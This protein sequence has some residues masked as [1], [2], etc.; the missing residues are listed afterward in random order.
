MSYVDMIQKTAL[1]QGLSTP[2]ISALTNLMVYVE[3]H[4]WQGACHSTSSALY[5]ALCELGLSPKLCVGEC[6][7]GAN[8]I[9]FDHSWIELDGKPY[10]VACTKRLDTGEPLC[11]PVI[12][13]IDVETGE[14]TDLRY[15]IAHLGLDFNTQMIRAMSFCDYMD[16]YPEVPEGLWT[17]VGACLG[18]AVDVP[19]LRHRY[20]GTER[21]YKK[22]VG[23]VYAG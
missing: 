15:G 19:Y 16:G 8:G 2:A 5:V 1:E 10:D 21:V 20:A 14:P 3:Q 17:V 6:R 13:G 18:H 23:G 4:D 22:K 11:P 7:Y 9:P 12:G